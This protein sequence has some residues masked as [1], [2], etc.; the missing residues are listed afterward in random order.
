[1]NTEI[2]KTI[3]Q[4]PKYEI[5]NHGQVRT[6][7][8]GFIRKPT[9]QNKHDLKVGVRKDGKLTFI[10][11]ARTVLSVFHSEPD[12]GMV[13][14]HRDGDRSNNHVGNLSWV[15]RADIMKVVTKRKTPSLTPSQVKEIRRIYPTGAINIQTIAEL[16][17]IPMGDIEEL[18]TDQTY[19]SSIYYPENFK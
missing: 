15:S 10:L 11:T 3:T 6:K 18:L 19:T 17:C 8:T 1:M 5:S 7:A 2:W 4:H 9:R 13:V 14:F 16:T 12:T